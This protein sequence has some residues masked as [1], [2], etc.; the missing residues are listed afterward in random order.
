MVYVLVLIMIEK[1][2]PRDLNI[3]SS[4]SKISYVDPNGISEDNDIFAEENLQKRLNTLRVSAVSIP[5][6]VVK[7]DLLLEKMVNLLRV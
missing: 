7:K 1:N 5:P 6:E 2:W 3:E 4:Q